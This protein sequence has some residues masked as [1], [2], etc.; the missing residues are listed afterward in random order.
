MRSTPLGGTGQRLEAKIGLYFYNARWHAP[1]LGRFA[2]ADTLIPGAG[3]PL[4]LDRYAYVMNNPLRYTDPSGH[5]ACFEDGYCP[6][7]GASEEELIAGWTT[8][9]GIKIEGKWSSS[10]KWKILFGVKA[11]GNAF[12]NVIGYINPN[13]A[14]KN[15]YG[16]GLK[17]KLNSGAADGSWA[18]ESSISGFSCDADSSGKIDARLVAHELGHIFNGIISIAGEM[19]PYDDLW[20]ASIRDDFGNW[21][22]GIKNNGTW[23]RGYDGYK[24]RGVPDLYHGPANWDDAATGTPNEEF[25]DM[26]MNWVFNSLDYRPKADGAGT[27][28]YNWMTTNMTEWLDRAGGY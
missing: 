2:Q 15:V 22:T 5:E 3:N 4:A 26:F 13:T 11:V 25:A 9:Y 1:V 6:E 16:S 19:T 23:A 28:R 8:F 14:F 12:A 24:S 7:V 27:A 21:V 10:D 18:C 20:R 17:F